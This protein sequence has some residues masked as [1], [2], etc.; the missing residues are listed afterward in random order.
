MS[1]LL[2]TSIVRALFA[3]DE[4]V[5]TR[6]AGIPL[7]DLVFTSVITEGE[8]LFGAARALG[9]RSRLLS[10]QIDEFLRMVA[11]VLPITRPVASIYAELCE[12]LAAR[13]RIIPVN[14]MWIAAVAISRD[15]TLVAHDR[16]FRE[17]RGLKLEDWLA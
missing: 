16:H 6:L 7:T 12:D 8:L 9:Q 1:Y 13:G 2:E 15:L 17:V 4:K 14:D 10:R 11:D 3:R 5:T